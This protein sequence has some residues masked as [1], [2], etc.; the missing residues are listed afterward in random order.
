MNYVFI[1]DDNYV[2]PTTVTMKS[3][4]EN[5]NE[6][7]KLFFHIFTTSMNEHN[8]EKLLNSALNNQ[9]KIYY[10][11]LNNYK[12]MIDKIIVRTHVTY[13]SLLKFEIANILKNVDRALYL[14][15]D[16]I[17]KKDLTE[18]FNLDL[19]NKYA[20][21]VPELWKYLDSDISDVNKQYFNSGVMMMNLKKMREDKISKK[22]WNKKIELSQDKKNR[23]MDQDTLNS[24][25]GDNVV[26]LGV[27]YN[28]NPYFYNKKYLNILSINEKKNYNNINDL[29][30]E[31]RIIHYVG[32]EDKPWLYETAR[33]I[34][35]WDKYYCLSVN[36]NIKLKREKINKNIYYY[37]DL[38]KKSIIK[39][40]WIK[41][42]K[43]IVK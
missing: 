41:T 31:V 42:I 3:I 35:E 37:L 24:V 2:M 28:F 5:T 26:F 21:V 10:I 16:I 33:L 36:K 12:E 6:K 34:N 30:D 29:M 9:I 7:E 19:N 22:L 27:K 32:K 43:K 38:L 11:D 40:G 15:S 13:A 23:T 18:L 1:C 17:V 14:D 8:S 4:I 25:L 20:A 39:N